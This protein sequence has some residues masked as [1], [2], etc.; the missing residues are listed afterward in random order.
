MVKPATVDVRIRRELREDGCQ[1]IS[2]PDV[3]L[4]HVLLRPGEPL[5]ETYL[6]VLQRMVEQQ[7]G[8]AVTLRL[9][10]MAATN[11]TAIGAG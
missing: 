10:D 4:F 8:K 9:I 1:Y 7:L 6:P 3:A 11:Q 5:V 2:S